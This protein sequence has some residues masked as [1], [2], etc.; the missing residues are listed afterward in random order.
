MMER[1]SKLCVVF[2]VCLVA[3]GAF[4]AQLSLEDCRRMAADGDVEALYQM[5]VRYETGAG[6]RKDNLR[7]LANYRK[8][9][10]K[11][12]AG[13]CRKL[14]DLYE[15]G[16]IVAKDPVAAAKYRAMAV[17]E[18]GEAAV[19]SA[20]E[21]MA[22]EQ[23]DEIEVALDYIIGRNGK[24]RDAKTGIRLLYSAAKDKPV[25]RRVFVQ[26]W[27]K[28]DLDAGLET[29]GAE[30]WD[31]IVPWFK[32][33]FDCGRHLMGGLILG[34]KAR[35]KKDYQ[36]AIAYYKTAGQ[37]GLAKA[38][39]YL[40]KLYDASVKE[41]NGG[42]PKSLH[43]ESKA[44]S[45]YEN[46]LK[47]DPNYEDASY[48]LGLIHMFGEGRNYQKALSAFG[49]LLKKHP[50]DMW[51]LLAY[52]RAGFALEEESFFKKWPNVERLIEKKR[53]GYMSDRERRDYNR[54]GADYE[55][56]LKR[57]EKYVVYIRRSAQKG[58]KVAVEFLNANKL[59]E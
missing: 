25:A 11:G 46:C 12:H 21:Q 56:M 49:G 39:F 42:G 34:H 33:Q 51:Y 19:S 30:E 10:D 3:S 16:S 52:G 35:I 38:W 8:A 48:H 55:Q 54:A 59:N 26:R 5:G 28:G 37:A 9:A 53:A 41:D 40:G 27:E 7:A 32:E 2:C 36:A 1:F 4:A 24:S 47:I 22:Q 13:A 6:V 45:A 17:G 57:R 29:I 18:S 43:S 50:D 44:K 15:S 20:K 31:L 14:A 23:V 58:C